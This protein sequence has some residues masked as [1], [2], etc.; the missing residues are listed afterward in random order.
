[1]PNNQSKYWFFTWETNAKQKQ[2]PEALT[3]CKFFDYNVA[4]AT[5]QL[6]RGEKAGKLHYQGVFTLDGPRQ[7]KMAVLRMF[8]ERFKNVHGLTPSRPHCISDALNYVSK[9]ETRVEGPFHSG[10]KNMFNDKFANSTKLNLWQQDLMSFMENN[11]SMLRDRKVIY[12]EDVVGGSGKS[13]FIKW[14]RTAQTK[15][16]FRALP[17]SAVDRVA[18]AMNLITKSCKLDIIAFDVTREQ[19]KDQSD[20]DL[21]AAVEQIKNG[22]IVDVMYGKFNESVFDPPIVIIFSNKPFL[23]VRQYL[24]FD[25]W[26]VCQPSD[27]GLIISDEGA[28]HPGAV[29]PAKFKLLKN[30]SYAA[31]T[32]Q[33]QHEL[34]DDETN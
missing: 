2:L 33:E 11:E 31:S 4:N 20:F 14:L 18:S 3:L 22:Y 17:I 24:S 32:T 5:F 25:R 30:S 7:S 16:V 8:E 26:I 27:D 21:Y 1:M 6:E 15:F 10:K 34:N 28:I 13:T 29:T 23:N 19:G 9:E 12:V